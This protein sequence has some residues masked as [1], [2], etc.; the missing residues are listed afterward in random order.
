MHAACIKLSNFLTNTGHRWIRSSWIRND[1]Q[2]NI[3]S[4]NSAVGL[5]HFMFTFIN[6]FLRPSLVCFANKLLD[7]W[8]GLRL[9]INNQFWWCCLVFFGWMCCLRRHTHMSFDW[10]SF[11][12]FIQ[13]L[14]YSQGLWLVP[15]HRVSHVK[16]KIK[17]HINKEF[18]ISQ[19]NF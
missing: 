5:L 3:Y 11:A 17:I 15:Q 8:G 4:A 18:V 1:R 7:D 19:L 9:G 16:I 13:S 14:Q 12:V 2:F 6:H 10:F